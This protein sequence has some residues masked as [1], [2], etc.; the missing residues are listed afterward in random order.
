VAHRSAAPATVTPIAPAIIT[1]T[2]NPVVTVDYADELKALG[3]T[4]G[5]TNGVLMHATQV[6]ASVGTI[7]QHPYRS[8][9]TAFQ[10]PLGS[11]GRLEISPSTPFPMV[12]SIAPS[13]TTAGGYTKLTAFAAEVF[14]HHSSAT[15]AVAMVAAGIS[16][17]AG[18]TV[19]GTVTV[20][21]SVSGGLQA[22][23][24]GASNSALNPFVRVDFYR[25]VAS[26]DTAEYLGSGSTPVAGLSAGN[27]ATY[28]YTLTDYAGNT[29]NGVTQRAA[30][31]GDQIIALAVRQTG[32]AT[33]ASAVLGGM[34]LA[35]DLSITA[36]VSVPVQ[37][38]GPNGFAQ[39]VTAGNGTTIVPVSTVGVYTATYPASINTLDAIELAGATTKTV[40]VSGNS[41]AAFAQVVYTASRIRVTLVNSG[42]ISGS[43]GTFTLTQAGQV[44]VVVPFTTTT[45]GSTPTERTVTLP[46]IGAWAIANSNVTTTSTNGASLTWTTAAGTVTAALQA[47][48]VVATTATYAQTVEYAPTSVTVPVG[49]TL[50]PAVKYA[51]LS[52]HCTA[53]TP[54]LTVSNSTFGSTVGSTTAVTRD[55]AFG[56]ANAASVLCASTVTGSDGF[57]YNFAEQ[58][59]IDPTITGST[60]NAVTYASANMKLVFAQGQC[61]VGAIAA[62]T[63]AAGTNMLAELAGTLL[64]LSVSDVG[65]TPAVTALNGIDPALFAAGNASSFKLLNNRT[66]NVMAAIPAV[67]KNGATFSFTVGAA[68]AMPFGSTTTYTVTIVKTTP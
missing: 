60:T 52:A 38:T 34:A 41:S 21:P 48:P 22:I 16:T 17:E 6:T 47:T 43:S 2:A 58:S 24:T 67:S 28:T 42:L 51:A 65:T 62:A 40:T 5:F 49:V 54:Y 57:P 53:G 68:V 12:S 11:T 14:S 45:A 30:Q 13:S 44:P 1:A 9:S 7:F 25:L 36:G 8:I 4:F 15:A 29:T 35:I 27:L 18:T 26:S 20:N 19:P 46:A 63:C 32:A 59:A 56:A 33:S 61:V 64:N 3:T 66:T 39:S 37:I 31:V 50:T 10:T 23:H 55:V